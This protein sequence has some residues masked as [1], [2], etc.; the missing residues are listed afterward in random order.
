[1]GRISRYANDTSINDNDRLIG[2]DGGTGV[3]GSSGATRNFT[4]QA[5]ANYINSRTSATVSRYDTDL[6]TATDLADPMQLDA[7][8][9]F[10][11]G[12]QEAHTI[13]NPS[14]ITNLVLP[15]SS[16]NAT[17]P[18]PDGSWVRITI[19]GDHG[20]VN[21]FAGSI[22]TANLGPGD[23]FMAGIDTSG[24]TVT[25]PHLLAFNRTER[26][27]FELIYIADDITINGVT[28]PVGW[29]IIN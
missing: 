19:V 23:R 8:G 25:D 20:G 29:I 14:G 6:I 24:N 9:Q 15:S 10:V 16:T 7:S 21:I 18:V 2:T 22:M 17:V 28:A 3:A 27:S 5:L 1:M 13:Y 4:V 12:L 11:L 26:V